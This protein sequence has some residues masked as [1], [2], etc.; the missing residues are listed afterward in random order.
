MAKGQ[1][2]L[3]GWLPQLNKIHAELLDRSKLGAYSPDHNH[4]RI[5]TILVRLH[6]DLLRPCYECP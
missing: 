4:L 2:T 5:A 1:F 6:Y 3:S